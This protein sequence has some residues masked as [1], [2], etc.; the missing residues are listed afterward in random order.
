MIIKIAFSA[1]YVDDHYDA[2]NLE[3][4]GEIGIVKTP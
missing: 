3:L 2:T 1:L 4:L